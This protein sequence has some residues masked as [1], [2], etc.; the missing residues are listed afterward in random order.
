MAAGARARARNQLRSTY[1]N[2]KHTLGITIATAAVLARAHGSFWTETFSGGLENGGL[3]PDGNISGWHDVRPV[4][5]A[6]WTGSG[7]HQF[8]TD[9]SVTLNVGRGYNGDL[10]AYLVHDSGYAVLLNRVGVS[11]SSAFG[12]GDAGFAGLTLSTG[13]A[14]DVHFYGGNGG[15]PLGGAWQPDG[16]AVDPVLT[17]GSALAGAPQ[18]ALLTSF[19]GLNPDGDWTLFIADV[20][21]GQASQVQDW[22]LS[23]TAVPE[24][25]V[26]AVLSGAGLA[27]GL[28]G[29]VLRRRRGK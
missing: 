3:V 19:T 20:V 16:R 27:L 5:D 13:A 21:S 22:T 12:Y 4:T 14:Q 1:M 18:T 26:G 15:L 8:I 23:I 11:G 25:A 28:G 2:W 9:V 24:P 17:P 29:W 10:F 7:D 6:G